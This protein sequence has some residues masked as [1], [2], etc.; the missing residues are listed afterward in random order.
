MYLDNKPDDAREVDTHEGI[1]KFDENCWDGTK[2]VSVATSND[3][4]VRWQDTGTR[5]MNQ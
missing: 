5:K 2:R 4:K 1:F 3:C